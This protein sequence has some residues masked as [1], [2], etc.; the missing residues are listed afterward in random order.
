MASDLEQGLRSIDPALAR[1]LAEVFIADERSLRPNRHNR[2]TDEPPSPRGRDSRLINQDTVDKHV[3]LYELAYT[4]VNKAVPDIVGDLPTMSDDP[5]YSHLTPEQF[6]A[7][8][9][10]QVFMDVLVL[11]GQNQSTQEIVEG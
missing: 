10:L 11:Y 6:L 9:A 4:I 2:A 1:E 5:E 3:G 8:S 7:A